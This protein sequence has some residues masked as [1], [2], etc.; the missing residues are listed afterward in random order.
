MALV[1]SHRA[2]AIGW[3]LRLHLQRRQHLARLLTHDADFHNKREDAHLCPVFAVA[4]LWHA[5]VRVYKI[6]AGRRI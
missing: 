5:Y 6:I 1:M 2:N 4:H 3:T